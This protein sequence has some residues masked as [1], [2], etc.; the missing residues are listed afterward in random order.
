MPSANTLYP[1][2]LAPFRIGNTVFRNHIFAGPSG[3][4]ES[5]PRGQFDIAELMYYERKAMGGCAVVTVSEVMADPFEEFSG[6]WPR[7][8]LDYG[9]VNFD[10][11]ADAISRHGAVPSQELNFEGIMSRLRGGND[12]PA[13]GPSAMEAFDGYS[14]TAA[15]TIQVNELSEEQILT[16]IRHFGKCA[17]AAKKKGFQMIKVHAAHGWGIQQF[18]S[19][20]INH[21]TDRWGGNTEN[22]CRFMVSIIDEI[23]R[24]CGR[25]FPVEVRISGTEVLEGSYDNEEL[26]RIAEQLDGH[27]D[28][29][30]VSVGKDFDNVHSFSRTELTMFY[31]FGRNVEYAAVVKQHVKHSLVG[32]IGGLSDPAYMEQLLAEGKCDIIYLVRELICDPDMPNKLMRGEA[33]KVRRCMRC[34]H[35]YT[36]CMNQGTVQCAINPEVGR[37]R[38][39]FYSLPPQAQRSILVAGGGIAGMQ[40][41]LTAAAQG[42][43][44]ILCEKS[45]QLGGVLLC[46]KEV[47]FKQRLHEYIEQQKALLAQS[48]VEVRLNTPVTPELIAAAAPDEVMIA[49]G[50]VPSLPP[51]QGVELPHVKMVQEVYAEPSLAKG[52]VVILGAGLAGTELAV[53]LHGLGIKATVVEMGPGIHDG[54]NEYQKMGLMDITEQLGIEFHFNSTALAITEDGISLRSGDREYLMEADTIVLATG[55]RPC[56]EEALKLAAAASRFSFLGDCKRVGNIASAT[57]DAYTASLYCGRYGS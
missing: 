25:S 35:C 23:H 14:H 27:A 1:H 7:S 37:E 33:D 29:I 4:T 55:M 22:R 3:F 26:G 15:K 41:A 36:H 48:A 5:D 49:L 16:I 47:P 39:V 13:W 45:D 40:A 28:I 6:G 57:G 44:V 19:P 8:N 18:Y 38:E 53:Y 50:S 34:M 51:I 52:K 2:L 31:P 9:V 10:R 21:R 43:K 24:V 56:Q 11:A 30:H 46:E 32:A 42:H 12:E 20:S 54:G 17:L